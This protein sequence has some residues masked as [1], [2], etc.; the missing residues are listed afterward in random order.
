MRQGRFEKKLT[1]DQ[2]RTVQSLYMDGWSMQRI[3]ELFGIT[4]QAVSK[5][6]QRRGKHGSKP[7]PTR[8]YHGRWTGSDGGGR[9]PV[10]ARERDEAGCIVTLR[11]QATGDMRSMH[12]PGLRRD[13]LRFIVRCID[14]D[15]RDWRVY[16]YSTPTTILADM[17][18]RMGYAPE[19]GPE[20]MALKS[21][22]RI[23]L[24]DP[25]LAA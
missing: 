15:V 3:G 19:R 1:K 17:S 24:L 2:V 8:G 12:V 11:D 16:S 14:V 18:G 9:T 23:D 20:F 21:I 13:A 10:H 7:V 4:R 5:L 22:G 25:S 6:L